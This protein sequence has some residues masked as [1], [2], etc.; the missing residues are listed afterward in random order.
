MLFY[1]LSAHTVVRRPKSRYINLFYVLQKKCTMT[2]NYLT[3]RTIPTVH[4]ETRLPFCKYVQKM[5][6]LICLKSTARAS[7]FVRSDYETM[8]AQGA[9]S[10]VLTIIS[11]FP[12]IWH[13]HGISQRLFPSTMQTLVSYHRLFH[14]IRHTRRDSRRRV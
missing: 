5:K 14:F 13:E 1:S 6:S 2:L 9:T 7:C 12:L 3:N 8:N 11:L 4:S 10:S